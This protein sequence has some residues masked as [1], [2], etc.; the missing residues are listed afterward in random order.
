GG[1]FDR[2]RAPCHGHRNRLRATEARRDAA[3]RSRGPPQ[4]PAVLRNQSSFQTRRRGSG[5]ALDGLDT[6]EPRVEDRLLPRNRTIESYPTRQDDCPPASLA[7]T[8]ARR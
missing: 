6:A 2:G 5:S 8:A 1:V 3:V 7:R 4:L